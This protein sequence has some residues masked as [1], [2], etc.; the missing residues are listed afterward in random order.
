[1]RR[2]LLLLFFAAC[3]PQGGDLQWK[4][5][6]KSEAPQT[7][8]HVAVTPP[9]EPAK[10]AA[11]PPNVDPPAPQQPMPAAPA[12]SQRKAP[13]GPSE[14]ISNSTAPI[15][16]EDEA[17]N[18]GGPGLTRK[19]WSMG[20]RKGGLD[21][22]R[23]LLPHDSFSLGRYLQAPRSFAAKGA[24]A[25]GDRDGDCLPDADEAVLGTNPD[26]PDS[27]GDGWF[28]GACNERRKLF[29]V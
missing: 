29:A 10:K 22:S 24:F 28:D 1:M 13:P 21:K 14:C 23:F 12:M 11:P 25:A 19:G 18:A 9:A 15:T 3:G 8:A 2:C 16:T 5:P 17:K 26:N 4:A 6:P 20:E 7:H 27:D